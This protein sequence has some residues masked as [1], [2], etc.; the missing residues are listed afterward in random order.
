MAIDDILVK[1]LVMN[2]R[3]HVNRQNFQSKKPLK[4]ITQDSLEQAHLRIFVALCGNLHSDLR[5]FNAEVCNIHFSM[6]ASLV[7]LLK[8]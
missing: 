8:R 6:M 2:Q 5:I 4:C 1:I 3:N 7:S